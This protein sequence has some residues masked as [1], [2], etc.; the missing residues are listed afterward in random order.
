MCSRTSLRR[1]WQ[2]W[3]KS[4]TSGERRH[5]R[6]PPYLPFNPSGRLGLNGAQNR[7]PRGRGKPKR[8]ESDRA[9]NPV[10]VLPA[11]VAVKRIE[12]ELRLFLGLAARILSQSDKFRRQGQTAPGRLPRK[13]RPKR[14]RLRY[15]S[16]VRSVGL[17]PG[18][19]L[20]EPPASL[21]AERAISRAISFQIVRSTRLRLAHRK[22]RNF[23]LFA[24]FAVS[25]SC[26]SGK[27]SAT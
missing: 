10:H 7:F 13:T 27:K 25:R 6:P 1:N 18:G 24:I 17:R 19:P 9:E 20:C 23:E 3:E 2:P 4:E 5:T 21:P 12:A 16:R 26:S 11:D 22:S 15:G 14:V 8:F